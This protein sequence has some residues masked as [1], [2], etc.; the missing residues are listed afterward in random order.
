MNTKSPK[1]KKQSLKAMTA[2][3]ARGAE[4][5]VSRALNG[6]AGLPSGGWAETDQA[7]REVVEELPHRSEREYSVHDLISAAMKLDHANRYEWRS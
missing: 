6:L 7:T 5:G 4:R 2:R 3:I 1:S